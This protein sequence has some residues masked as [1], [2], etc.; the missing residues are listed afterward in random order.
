MGS[1]LDIIH[2]NSLSQAQLPLIIRTSKSNFFFLIELEQ[3]TYLLVMF[4]VIIDYKILIFLCYS[5]H[6]CYYIKYIIQQMHSM[7]HHLWRKSTPTCFVTKVPCSE[8]YIAKSL[9]SDM[10]VYVHSSL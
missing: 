2:K 6:A 1:L 9:H 3:C 5:Y 10:P 8:S 4:F 7:V